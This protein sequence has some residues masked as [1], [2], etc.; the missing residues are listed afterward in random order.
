MR[1]VLLNCG[2]RLA[3][4]EARIE[5]L[6]DGYKVYSYPRESAVYQA[7]IQQ[8]LTGLTST[9]NAYKDGRHSGDVHISDITTG[10]KREHRTITGHYAPDLFRN[11]GGVRFYTHRRE[12]SKM[13]RSI[14]AIID[15]VMRGEGNDGTAD[16]VCTQ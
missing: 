5:P 9:L 8:G 10:A 4:H 2:A 1:T 11:A 3:T 16:T 15:A 7:L 12:E 14:G 6:K 13:I